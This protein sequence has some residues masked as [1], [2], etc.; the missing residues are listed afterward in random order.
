MN[1]IA[2]G[3]LLILQATGL[4][5]HV[6]PHAQTRIVDA[7]QATTAKAPN[8]A[9]ILPMALPVQSSNEP[10]ALST[11]SA[12]AI[13]RTTG[14][15][16]YGQN[17]V[18]KRPLASI[19]K[20]MTILTVLNHHS[21]DDSV[22]IGQLP[23]YPSDAEI[24]GFRTG[25]TF[26][27]GDLVKAALI[28][29]ANDAADAL[30]IYDA[31]SITKFAAQMNI[32]LSQWGIEGARFS[33]PSGLNDTGNYTTAIALAKIA[34]LALVNPTIQ[35]TVTMRSGS[36]TDTA[37]E[38]F[39][40]NTTNE[41]LATGQFYGIKTG[42]TLLAG[43]CFVGLAHVNGHEVITVILGSNNRFGDTLKLTNWIGRDWQW[44]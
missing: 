3:L 31:G 35:Q 6:S 24:M 42:Y 37:G 26:K 1:H 39:T 4:W 21:V 22:T 14:I 18:A 29:S 27:L 20:I 28:P 7:T 44:L 15:Q 38:T 30:A 23:V 41:L 8:Q 16:L 25:Q 33:N 11:A 5:S 34:E 12:Y 43:E 10:L 32:K 13:D 17:V 36:I 19:T 9:I 2:L 40:F